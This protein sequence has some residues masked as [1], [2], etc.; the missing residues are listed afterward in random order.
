MAA[1]K[2]KEW[3]EMIERGMRRH[4][5]QQAV[6]Q[7]RRMR[8]LRKYIPI[9]IVLGLLASI[10]Y[11]LLWGWETFLQDFLSWVIGITIVTTVLALFPRR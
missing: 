5:Q 3:A 1:M 7:N 10:L 4:E 11:V 8:D 6:E 9:P 2:R